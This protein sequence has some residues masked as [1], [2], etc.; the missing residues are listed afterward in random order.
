MLALCVSLAFVACD[1]V[2]DSQQGGTSEKETVAMDHDYREVDENLETLGKSTGYMI[3]Y[4]VSSSSTDEQA[5]RFSVTLGMK[6]DIYYVKSEDGDQAYYDL[7]DENSAVIYTKHSGESQWSKYSVSYEQ[8]EKAA[9]LSTIKA[10]FLSFA[11]AY[12]IFASS[13]A[14]KSTA[15]VC[16]R[17]CDKYAV[18]YS[19]A[20]FGN[21]SLSYEVCIDAETSVCLKLYCAGSFEGT[22]GTVNFECTAFDTNPT[23]TLPTV[24]EEE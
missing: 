1:N 16:G 13:D 21:I 3:T 12:N 18:K 23:I 6:G 10:E 4:S 17:T 11:Q 19:F 24:V 22:G 14:T 9:Y 2:D 20:A 8:T 5:E 7:S 15:T